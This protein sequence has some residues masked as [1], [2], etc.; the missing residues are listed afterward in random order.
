MAQDG[1]QTFV[2]ERPIPGVGSFP[3][4][5]KEGISRASNAAIAQMEGKVEWVHSYLTEVGTVCIYRATDEGQIAD[6]A[7]LAGAPLG[8]I[9]A[10]DRVLPD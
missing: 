7:Q 6:H 8:P 5:R 3:L 9:T 10:V 4:A 1:L 2:I